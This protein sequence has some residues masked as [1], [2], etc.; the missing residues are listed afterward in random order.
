MTIPTYDASLFIVQQGT[1]KKIIH[2][3]KKQGATG[4]T[5][6]MGR[7][8]NVKNKLSKLLDIDEVRREIV[9]IITSSNYTNTFLNAMDDKFKFN[10]RN[11]GIAMT[12]PITQIIGSQLFANEKSGERKETSMYKAII[13]IVD[14]GSAEGVINASRASGSQGATII[15]ARGSGIHETNKLFNMEITPEKEV[16]LVI[17][18]KDN[19][20][21]INRSI[22]DY[23]DIET[24]G[25]GILFVQDVGKVIGLFEEPSEK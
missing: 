19:V 13:T 3:G 20:D 8:I 25:N 23:L 24:P 1:A 6:F 7:G 14:K 10:K 15:N 2:Y 16:V 22:S 18:H 4:C 17:A 5:V 21:D 9:M 12:L 11:H